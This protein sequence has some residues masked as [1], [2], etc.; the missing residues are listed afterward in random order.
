[1]LRRHRLKPA[2]R[3][4]GPSWGEVLR[5]QATSFDPS[6]E[7]VS[8]PAGHFSAILRELPLIVDASRSRHRPF[9]LFALF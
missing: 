6:R 3:R 1:V 8:L 4:S 2:P 5:A 7:C 9:R